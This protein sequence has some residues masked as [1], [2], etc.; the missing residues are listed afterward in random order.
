M[1]ETKEQKMTLLGAGILVLVLSVITLTSRPEFVYKERA[2]NASN[3]QTLDAQKYLAYLS[4]LK[5]DPAASKQLFEQILSTQ[6]IQKAVEEELEVSRPVRQPALRT[7]MLA[8]A[9]A[10]SKQSVTDYLAKITGSVLNYDAQVAGLNKNFF[11]ETPSDSGKVANS[12]EKVLNEIYKLPA[13]TDA[14]ELRDSVINLFDSYQNLLAAATEYE[15]GTLKDPW[16]AVYGEYVNLNAQS[17]AIQKEVEKISGKYQI[18]SVQIVPVYAFAKDQWSI[19]PTAHAFLGIGDV[20]I[21]LGDIPRIIKEAVEEGLVNSFSQFMGSMLNKLIAKIEAN[22]KIANF[23]YYTD[24]LVAGQYTDDYLQKYVNDQ[25]DRQ[26]IKRFIPQFACGENPED[27]KPVFQAK[28][29]AYLGFDIASLSP[30]DPQFYE[31]L[32]RV[33]DPLSFSAGWEQYYEGIAEQAKTEAEKAAERELVSPGVKSPRDTTNAAIAISVNNIVSASR[34]SLNA[35]LNL[36]QNS[37]K[38]FI[39]GFVSQLTQNLANKFVFQ[40]ASAEGGVLGVLK[41]QKVCLSAAQLAP[42]LPIELTTYEAPPAAPTQEELLQQ[43]CAKYPRGCT[44]MPTPDT[45]N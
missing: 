27:L 7:E 1:L 4:S 31:K 11:S 38:N 32:N 9:I 2:Q 6:D 35:L 37:S 24:A 17:A 10:S 43:E 39:S 22:Y 25:L 28:A 18:A 12:T 15:S 14:T 30:S 34:A 23:L 42:V 13:P 33:G 36:G 45:N 44:V 20:S 29:K 8:P 19:V 26:I 16:P 5:I 41:E 40:G 3:Q 21:T